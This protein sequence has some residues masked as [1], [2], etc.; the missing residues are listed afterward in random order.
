MLKSRLRSFV[1]KELRE[2]WPP[3]LFFAIAFNLLVLTTQLILADYLVHFAS[4]M[5]ATTCAL[6]VGKSVLLANALPFFSRFDTAPM[7]QPV[8]FKTFVYWAVVFLV[9]FLEKLIEWEAR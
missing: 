1:V 7:I 9:R 3:T 6:V 2:V 5:L 4:F 8:L